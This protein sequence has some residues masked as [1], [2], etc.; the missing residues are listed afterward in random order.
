MDRNQLIGSCEKMSAAW[1]ADERLMRV[2]EMAPTIMS[3]TGLDDLWGIDL[4]VEL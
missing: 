2:A 4:A 3:P 1:E